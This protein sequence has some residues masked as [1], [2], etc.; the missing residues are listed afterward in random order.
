MWLH[1][2]E[3]LPLHLSA[4]GLHQFLRHPVFIH[5]H[6]KTFFTSPGDAVEEGMEEDPESLLFKTFE[7][8]AA[9]ACPPGVEEPVVVAAEVS[10]LPH[11]LDQ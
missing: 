6:H 7:V 5:I 8:A 2:E 10:L 3:H 11:V 1:A 4:F 9:P